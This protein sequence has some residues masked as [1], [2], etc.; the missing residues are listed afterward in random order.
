MTG[1]E[2][3]AEASKKVQK[4]ETI[5]RSKR[6]GLTFPVARLHR[7]LREGQFRFRVASGS[8]VYLAAVLEYLV[9]E[10]LELAGNAARDN[11]KARIIPRHLQLAIRNDEELNKLLGTVTIAQG[12]VMP[13]IHASLLPKKSKSRENSSASTGRTVVISS[14]SQNEGEPEEDQ[15]EESP[16]EELEDEGQEDQET[17]MEKDNI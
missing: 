17:P 5:S 11:R 6:A 2:N 8:P 13:N 1:K 3:L 7:K 16:A 15:I 9:A 14:A 4:N 10:I 12:G